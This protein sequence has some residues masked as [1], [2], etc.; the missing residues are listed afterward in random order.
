M[1][2]LS[3]LFSVF[4]IIYCKLLVLSL[5]VFRMVVGSYNGHNLGVHCVTPRQHQEPHSIVPY[6]ALKEHL[7]Q[8]DDLNYV[9]S[10]N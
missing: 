3:G 9:I 2:F 4:C 7:E 5:L 1:T 10:V 8:S 6:Y